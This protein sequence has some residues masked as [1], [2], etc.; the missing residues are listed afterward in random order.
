MQQGGA[1][2]KCDHMQYRR[3]NFTVLSQIHVSWPTVCVCVGMNHASFFPKAMES[4][5]EIPLGSTSKLRKMSK[6]AQKSDVSAIKHLANATRHILNFDSLL[7]EFSI[8]PPRTHSE[9]DLLSWPV[10]IAT[11]DEERKQN[12]DREFSKVFRYFS[13]FP[14]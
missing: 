7:S 3:L 14:D 10:L 4:S 2:S 13:L 11:G 5:G 9:S 6:L 1:S 8:R 12:L